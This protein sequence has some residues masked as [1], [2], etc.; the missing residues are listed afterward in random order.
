M[1]FEKKT[2]AIANKIRNFTTESLVENLLKRLHADYDGPTG[3]ERAWVTCMLL[4]WVLENKPKSTARVAQP[5]DVYKLTNDIWNLQGDATA[6]AV[7]SES[8]MLSMRPF[9]LTQLRF[10]Q[11][12]IIH[13]YFLVRLYSIMVSVNES[14]AF[15]N[16]FKQATNVELDR[17]YSL[18]LLLIQLFANTK[19]VYL[20]YKDMLTNF[21]PAFSVDEIAAILSAL[22][23]NVGDLKA[24][25]RERRL[26]L[27]A[28]K[29]AEYCAETHLTRY[30]LL[31][32]PDS[33][34]TSH[35]YVASI[36]VSEFVLRTLKAID[37]SGFRNKFSRAF[38]DYMGQ[39]FQDFGIPVIHESLLNDHYKKNGL[40]G[41]VVDFLLNS[42]GRSVLFDAKGVE[43]RDELLTTD[44]PKTIKDKLRDTLLK[45]VEQAA[46]CSTLLDSSNYPN[47]ADYS[48]RFAL[49]VTHKE[50]YFGGGPQL[51]DYLREYSDDKLLDVV[52]GCIPLENIHFCSIAE[53]EGITAICTKS[54]TSIP[55]FLQY[56]TEQNQDSVTAKFEMRQQLESFIKECDMEHGAP[57]GSQ[58]VYQDYETLMNEGQ[59]AIAESKQYWREGGT[60]KALE[61]LQKLAQLKGKLSS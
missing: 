39:V 36:G 9:L 50:F 22:G 45:G 49:I 12:Q 17:F 3:M 20:P 8:L 58:Q 33:L 27:G 47:F 41:K 61:Y 54:G 59:Q 5:K 14:P 10:Q 21:H 29:K 51:A 35:T 34:T 1:S 11:P 57:I 24:H 18:S 25:F 2:K 15:K 26:T 40:Q 44:S 16:S 13:A 19:S 4:E 7:G 48:H 60:D 52:S 23:A 56:C 30:P 31:L 53:L 46:K 55:D 6:S 28:I 32:L 38:E 43:P 42:N 37:P